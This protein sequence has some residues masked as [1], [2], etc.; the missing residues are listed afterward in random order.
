MKIEKPI[1]WFDVETTGTSITE[2]RIIEICLIKQSP[3]NKFTKLYHLVNPESK[4]SEPGAIEKHGI[5]KDKLVDKPVFKKIAQEILDFIEGCDL[6]GYNAFRFDIPIL[7]EEMLRAGFRFNHRNF[8]ILDPYLMLLHFLPRDLGSVYERFT[9][10]KLENAHTAESDIKAT[11][12][13]FYKMAKEFDV[14]STVNELDNIIIDRTNLVD[15]NQKFIFDSDGKKIL[16]NF[17]KY[18]GTGFDEVFDKD[19]KYIKWFISAD[20]PYESKAI[21]NKLYLRRKG[22]FAATKGYE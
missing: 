10:K 18:K 1:V 20:F 17:G 15:L 12:E 7:A 2:D 5:T 3:D 14:P 9:G 19:P 11:I 6:G 8:K 22:D 21:A 4:D 16:F 13:I